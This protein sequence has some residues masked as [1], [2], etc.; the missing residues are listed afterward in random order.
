V[1]KGKFSKEQRDTVLMTAVELAKNEE[2]QD[3][4]LQQCQAR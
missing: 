3:Q 4:T 2:E 1:F